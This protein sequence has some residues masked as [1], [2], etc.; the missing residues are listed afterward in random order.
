M[1][2]LIVTQKAATRQSVLIMKVVQTG[3]APNQEWNLKAG[4]DLELLSVCRSHEAAGQ[5]SNLNGGLRIVAVKQTSLKLGDQNIFCDLLTS[6]FI[7]SFV[8]PHGSRTLTACT[9]LHCCLPVSVIQ[10]IML[11]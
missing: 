10:A 4:T 11:G 6:A 8:R 7:L 3:N 2:N 1:E 5:P 9:Q